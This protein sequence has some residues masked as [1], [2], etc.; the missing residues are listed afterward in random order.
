MH[1]AVEARE[2]VRER[3]GGGREKERK[4]GRLRA[5]G[6]VAGEGRW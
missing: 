6:R 1:K 3:E 4:E 2:R 5:G